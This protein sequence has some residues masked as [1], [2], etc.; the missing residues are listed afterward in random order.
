MG[1]K[2]IEKLLSV[3]PIGAFDKIKSNYL[4]YFKTAYKFRETSS[5][6]Y[7]DFSYLNA[8]LYGSD[9]NNEHTPG[10]I[11]EDGNLYK[12]PFCELLPEYESAGQKLED[13]VKKDN[14]IKWPAHFSEFI[15]RG[16]MKPSDPSRSYIPYAHQYEML[17]FA[18]GHRKNVVITSGTGS[19]KTESFMLPLFASLLQEASKWKQQNY[20][21]VWYAQRNQNGEYDN[22]YQ[23]LGE[24]RPAALRA[25]ILYPMNAL[26]NDQMS[27]LRQA[28][29]SEDIRSF[30]DDIKYGYKGNRIFFGRYNG[31]TIGARDQDLAGSESMKKCA[32]ELS[33]IVYQSINISRKI[34]GKDLDADAEFVAPRFSDDPNQ[35]KIGSEMLTRWDMQS[36]PPDVLITNVSMLSIALMRSYEDSI[37]ENTK[38]YYKNNPDAV[39]HLIVDELHL[40]RGTAGSEVACLLRMFLERIGVPPTIKDA[41]GRTVANPR[42]RILASSASLG[43][44]SEAFLEEFFGV[45]NEDQTPAFTI[46][47]AN[48]D[49]CVKDNSLSINYND[50]C[51]FATHHDPLGL[52][53]V[54]DGFSDSLLIKNTLAQKYGCANIEEFIKQYH[55]Q[56]F[57]DF[58]EAVKISEKNNLG[59]VSY[60]Y[61]PAP[62]SQIAS[63]LQCSNDA[64]RGFFIFRGD[65]TVNALSNEYKLPRIRFH[66]FFKYIE[67]LWGELQDPASHQGQCIGSLMYEPHEITTDGSGRTHRV[68]ELLR[69]ECCGT[70]FIGGNRLTQGDKTIALLLNTPDLESIPNRNATP[71]VQNKLYRDYAVFLPT[72]NPPVFLPQYPYVD[73]NGKEKRGSK[74]CHGAWVESWLS[75]Y[76]GSISKAIKPDGI[77]GYLYIFEEETNST[78]QEIGFDKVGSISALPCQCPCCNR[79]YVKRIYTKSPIRSFRTG[80][81]RSNQL[82]TKELLYQLNDTK[83]EAKQKNAGPGEYYQTHGKLIGFSDSRQD[84]AEQSYGIAQEHFRDVVRYFFINTIKNGLNSGNLNTTLSTVKNKIIK[85]IDDPDTCLSIIERGIADDSLKKILDSIVT[86]NISDNQKIA[87]ITGVT[88]PQ[89]TAYPLNRM[90]SSDGTKLDGDIVRDL[91]SIG[92]NPAAVDYD[93]QYYGASKI[94]WDQF[95][96]WQRLQSKDKNRQPVEIQPDGSQKYVFDSKMVIDRLASYIYNNC[97][98][99]YMGLSAED[100]GLGYVV[101]KEATTTREKKILSD[102]QNELNKYS[103][104]LVAFDFL[105]A[106]IRILGDNYRF[107]D[108]DSQ[109]N[110]TWKHYSSNRYEECFSRECKAHIIDITGNNNDSTLGDILFE[111]LESFATKGILLDMTKLSF[112]MVDDQSPFYKC[113]KCGRVHLHRG[114]GRCTNTACREILPTTPTGYVSE[115]RKNHFI[116]YD[117]VTEPREACRLHTEE[118]TGQT[119]DQTRRLLDFKNVI[120]DDTDPNG[121][122]VVYSRRAKEIDMLNVTTTMEVGVDI[123]SLQAVYQGN[124]PPTRYNYQQRV[125]RGGRR[126][127]AFS[128]AVTF[129]RGRSHDSY[130]YKYAL[131]EITGGKPK[132]PTL[133]VNPIHNGT[134]NLSIIKRVILKHVLMYAFSDIRIGAPEGYIVDGDTHGQFGKV[135][136]WPTTRVALSNWISRNKSVIQT[137]TD[138][139]LK[140]FGLSGSQCHKE[141]LDWIKNDLLSQVDSAVASTNVQGLAQA[142]AEYGLLPLYGMPTTMRVLIHG[143]SRNHTEFRTI[144]RSLEQSITE[145]ALGAIKTKDSGFYRSVGLTVPRVESLESAGKDPNVFS[146]TR[147]DLDPLEYNRCLTYDVNSEI[148]KIEKRSV[149]PNNHQETLLVIPKAFRTG[150]VSGNTGKIKENTDSRHSFSQSRVYVNEST[151]YYDASFANTECKLWNCDDRNKT[152]VWHINDNNGKKFPIVRAYRSYGKKTIDPVFYQGNIKANNADYTEELLDYAPQY[153]DV[154]YKGIDWGPDKDGQPGQKYTWYISDN[155]YKVALGANKVTEVLRLSVSNFNSAVNLDLN[156]GNV[157]AIKA[158]FYSAATLIQRYFADEIDIEPSEIEISVQSHNG[159][160]VVYLSDSLDNGAGFI[161]MLCSIGANGK[162]HLLEIMEDIVS[163]DPQ[164]PF[165]KALYKHKDICKTACHNCLKSYDNQGLHHILDWRLGVDLIQLMLDSTYDMGF[166]DMSKTPYG[167]LEDLMKEIVSSTQMAN[168]NLSIKKVGNYFIISEKIGGF[169][170]PANSYLIHPLWNDGQLPQ[171]KNMRRAHNIFQLFRGIFT[172]TDRDTQNHLI[173]QA[174]NSIGIIEDDEDLG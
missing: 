76:D 93:D 116:S 137:I 84:A 31:E 131:D 124:M 4:R 37:F 3:D 172:T 57:F 127:Q 77:H 118:L 23:R 148:Q 142:M 106:Y 143:D 2:R 155:E 85:N 160:P 29:D 88:A 7:D 55:E 16:L 74:D 19:G 58:K 134:I 39:F 96:D 102:L 135:S 47:G 133:S 87:E 79:N 70:L 48:S 117:I 129:C 91:L 105:N 21:P 149:D 101:A 157:S 6:L 140:Q 73:A 86:K 107:N 52:R 145:F 100:A 64:I 53:Y 22:P 44:D 78:C 46:I 150:I 17:K 167:D 159:K 38:D 146:T 69:C 174:S 166:S 130:F 158:A 71:M 147:N 43:D 5:P 162:S 154:R 99:R 171:L 139:Y 68:L 151:N 54:D 59:Q 98:G 164:S 81:K 161:R 168:S 83:Q 97:F 128:A 13:L 144:G 113:E 112:V 120:L 121:N 32:R 92:I 65:E 34:S 9:A 25:L 45:Y 80:I 27:R 61:V 111:A 132:D 10:L 126:G 28:L 66:Q 1:K 110:K 156:T 36:Y 169:P 35:N 103:T 153:L 14:S 20:N 33:D 40:H 24:T 119:D 8:R 50:F 67:G 90:V 51:P 94:F 109:K 60:R 125:G 26:V 136:D 41:E 114:I 15:S 42:L 72:D 152:E 82:L 89:S 173:A 11:E 163:P 75:P 56:I 104:G 49:L 138:V 122:P 95:Y 108:P 141:L 30:F 170:I 12:E 18:F 62:V 123:G 115:L 165:I 63:K